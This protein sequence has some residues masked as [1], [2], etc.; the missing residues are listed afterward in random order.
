M[1]RTVPPTPKALALDLDG[2]LTNSEKKITPFVKREVL[3]A[4]RSGVHIILASGRP[5]IGMAHVADELELGK[6]GGYILS[7]NGAK[8]V[9]WSAKKTVFESTLSRHAVE[10]C[11]AASHVFDVETIVYDDNG[12]YSENIA[13]KYVE[14]ERY[15][16]SA[17]ATQVDELAQMVT[18]APNKMMVVGEP[19]EL[20]PALNWLSSELRSDADVFLSEPYFIE[21]TPRGIRKDAALAILMEYLNLNLNDLMA[22]GDGLNDIPMLK[23][24]GLAI[25]ME[26]AYPETKEYAD[27]IAP[28]NDENGVA[29][30]VRQF[31]TKDA[32]C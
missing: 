24:A 2:T 28:S 12:L 16:N 11:C 21:I 22:C 8:I 30:A 17:I 7:N 9:E 13:A 1:M 29:A 26:N 4:A 25:A 19:D 20:K 14:K 31:I 6:C 23:C 18:W 15:N 32:S 3:A 27:W 5:V 10:A